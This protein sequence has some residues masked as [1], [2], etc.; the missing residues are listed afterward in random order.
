MGY[1]ATKN[2]QHIQLVTK[3][4]EEQKRAP[5]S[6]TGLVGHVWFMPSM[7]HRLKEIEKWLKNVED[8]SKKNEEDI[9]KME[10]RVGKLEGLE[11]RMG[12]SEEAVFEEMRER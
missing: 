4:L 9:V 5:A 12:S 1:G 7:N 8:A 6:P 2:M 3:I 10:N 11:N